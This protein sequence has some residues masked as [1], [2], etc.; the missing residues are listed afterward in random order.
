[1]RLLENLK[2]RVCLHLWLIV[3]LLVGAGLGGSLQEGQV[4]DTQ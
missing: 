3:F 1:M 4:L 2:L